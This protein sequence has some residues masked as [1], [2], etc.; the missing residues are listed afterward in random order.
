MAQCINLTFHIFLKS[1]LLDILPV[2]MDV[3][4]LLM[5]LQKISCIREITGWIISYL[6]DLDLFYSPSD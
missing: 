1:R 5:T 2:K 4:A 6:I 3:T